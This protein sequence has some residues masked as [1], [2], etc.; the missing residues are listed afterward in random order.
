MLV[1]QVGLHQTD[2]QEKTSASCG[3][4]DPVFTGVALRSLTRTFGP[5]LSD[6]PGKLLSFTSRGG[7]YDTLMRTFAIAKRRLRGRGLAAISAG[8]SRFLLLKGDL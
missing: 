1:L 5:A 4:V 7:L 2:R 8:L 3:Q 6:A